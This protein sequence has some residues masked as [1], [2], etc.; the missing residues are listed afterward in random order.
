LLSLGS[1]FRHPPDCPVN[2]R[3]SAAG[4]MNAALR[5]TAAIDDDRPDGMTAV[6]HKSLYSADHHETTRGLCACLDYGFRIISIITLSHP[7]VTGKQA[8]KLQTL[9]DA[10]EAAIAAYQSSEWGQHIGIVNQ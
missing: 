9:S 5:S 1:T 3:D 6:S 4:Q 8:A 10:K 2:G 7:T